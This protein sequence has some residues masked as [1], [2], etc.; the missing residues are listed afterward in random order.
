[1]SKMKVY[2]SLFPY[3]EKAVEKLRHIK[4]GAL[5]MDTG[6]GKTRTGLELVRVR[7]EAGKVNHVIWL[8]PC[9][10]KNDIRRGIREH[11][12]LDDLGCLDIVGIETLSSSYREQRRLLDLVQ[13]CSAY[14]IVD[15]SSMVKNPR[16]IRSVRI[17]ELAKHCRYKLILSGTPVSRN[18]ADLYAQ[19]ALLDW[20]ILGYQS[21]FSF[22][23]NHLEYYTVVLPSG[24]E[25]KTDQVKRVLNVDYLAAK[26]APY[27][28]QVRKD[29]CLEL[30][31][32]RYQVRTFDL[33]PG[34]NWLYEET[35]SLYLANVQDWRN[36]TIYKLFTAL[37]HVSSGRRVL[38]D[39]S[40]H[41]E[42]EPFF[43]SPFENPRIQCLEE[44]LNIIEKEKAII[45]C[46]YKSEAGEIEALLNRMGITW[47]DFT[48]QT[49][50][51]QRQKNLLLFRG[52]AQVMIS[53]K[54][55]GAYGL[56]LQFCH[57]IIFYD[58][59]FDYAT[60]AQAEDRVYRIGQEHDVSI[61]DICANNTIDSFIASNLT[62]KE[63]MLECFK[64][65]VKKLKEK[66]WE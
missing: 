7:M 18:E 48:G 24:R 21:F 56:N 44:T 27:T 33:T 51:K 35:K 12:N 28:Y 11:S 17:Q 47:V 8:C 39:P 1:M 32:K 46:K 10:I 19:W 62:Q 53:N 65:Y 9:N 49:S 55:C 40:E 61:Y 31:A 64:D 41:M 23:A 42:T 4:V 60:R 22:A 20:R 2:T 59:D 34:Q 57:N 58:N 63:C 43:S 38:T 52:D 3:Q 37:Q 5:Y 6:T 50:S 25:V 36:E 13:R 30:P 54:S 26:I 29:E 66:K 45:F 14:L 16:A 15:E